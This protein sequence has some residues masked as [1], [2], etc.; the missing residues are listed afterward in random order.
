[1]GGIFSAPAAPQPVAAP[2]PPK[3][4]DAAVQAKA[5]AERRRLQLQ[6]GR[7]S[8]ILTSGQGVVGGVSS[9]KKVL[10]GE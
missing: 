2:A 4:D 1:M 5:A 6:Q 8:T 7:A 10:L 9:A 3:I